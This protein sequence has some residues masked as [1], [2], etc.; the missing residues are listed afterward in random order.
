M[1]D[2]VIDE[3]KGIGYFKSLRDSFNTSNLVTYD[4]AIWGN[5]NLSFA[6][7]NNEYDL[8]LKKDA[9]VRNLLGIDRSLSLTCPLGNTFLEV[10]NRILKVLFSR[11]D[12]DMS[13]PIRAHAIIVSESLDMNI[14]MVVA[15]RDCAIVVLKSKNTN[16]SVVMHLG[17]PQI[18]QEFH[19]HVMLYTSSFLK[20]NDLSDYVVYIYP[21]ITQKNYKLSKEK[22]RLL[23]GRFDEYLDKERA[24]NFIGVFTDYISRNYGIA[25]IINSGIDNYESAKNGNMYSYTYAKEVGEQDSSVIGCHNVA[26]K[27]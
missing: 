20:R 10:N 7:D 25:N 18:L 21:H 6:K 26:I 15:P 22:I 4:N 8:I 3:E 9:N 14:G 23:N 27:I 13:I 12:N 1:Q 19:K 2:F 24:F 5:M 16:V 17:S 11:R